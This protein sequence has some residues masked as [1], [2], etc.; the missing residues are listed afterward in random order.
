MVDRLDATY[1]YLLGRKKGPNQSGVK[2]DINREVRDALVP[3]QLRREMADILYK[4]S[5]QNLCSGGI[6]EASLKFQENKF[7]V[8]RACC[9]FQDLADDDLVLALAPPTQ[10]PEN[11]QV[12][13][14]WDWHLVAYR[15]NPDI[16]AVI[17]G[18]PSA[19]M[20]LAN[21]DLLPLRDSLVTSA[22]Y[23]GEFSLCPPEEAAIGKYSQTNQVL[24]LPSIGVLSLGNSLI[25]AATKLDLINKLGEITLLVE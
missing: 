23:I 22:E 18:Q 7:L 14:H 16:N 17:L 4:V 12:P 11:E 8:T 5:Q 9:W 6:S 3:T 15:N 20:A 21:K 1:Q 13:L 19:V 2:S 10:L 24:I 25:E